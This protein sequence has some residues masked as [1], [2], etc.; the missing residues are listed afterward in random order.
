MNEPEPVIS[1][2]KPNLNSPLEKKLEKKNTS[3]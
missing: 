3:N 1:S 2:K